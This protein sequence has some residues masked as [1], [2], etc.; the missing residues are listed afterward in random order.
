MLIAALTLV[1]LKIPRT[2]AAR[3]LPECDAIA[4][5]N[6]KPIRSVTHFDTKP[7]PH[8]ADYQKFI[9]STGIVFERDLDQV[10]FALTRMPDPKGPNGPVAFSEVFIGHFD[11]ARLNCLSQ[12]RSH[13]I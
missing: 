1:R 7:V 3:L 5:V 8:S 12:Q 2:E 10:A 6:L 4:F 9:D 13:G 11:S